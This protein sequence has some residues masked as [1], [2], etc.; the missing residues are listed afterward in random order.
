MAWHLRA[1][2]WS[3]SIHPWVDYAQYEEKR[4]CKEYVMDTVNYSFIRC[5]DMEDKRGARAESGGWMI[6]TLFLSDAPMSPTFSSSIMPALSKTVW[7]FQVK[8]LFSS[9]MMK[10]NKSFEAHLPLAG[11]PD[12]EMFQKH[13]KIGINVVSNIYFPLAGPS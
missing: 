11:N 13:S 5:G 12:F 9:K 10:W 3:R 6:A 8:N 4:A 2:C 1:Q 7:S